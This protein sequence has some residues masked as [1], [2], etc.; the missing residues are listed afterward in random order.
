MAAARAAVRHRRVTGATHDQAAK[1]SVATTDRGQVCSRASRAGRA[2]QIPDAIL[3]APSLTRPGVATVEG[4]GLCASRALAPALAAG[5]QELAQRAGCLAGAP[6]DDEREAAGAAREEVW[7]EGHSCQQEGSTR[8]LL[9]R[10]HA[11]RTQRGGCCGADQSNSSAQL[12]SD[13]N[14]HCSLVLR[15]LASLEES[16]G[17]SGPP[18]PAGAAAEAAASWHL[19]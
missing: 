17:S 4:A 7:Q 16:P 12:D 18:V 8:S 1:D 14:R 15:S 11:R 13:N 6:R 2:G 9:G 10:A 19:A 5:T 3:A